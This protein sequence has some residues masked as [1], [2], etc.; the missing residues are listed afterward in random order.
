MERHHRAGAFAGVGGV[1]A[2]LF[3]VVASQFFL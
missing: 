1:D 2:L 3:F